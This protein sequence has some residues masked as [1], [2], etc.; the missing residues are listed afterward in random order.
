MNAFDILKERGFVEQI[1]DE[2]GV[3]KH[4]ASPQ[5]VYA[6]FDPSAKSLHLGN[7]V[8]LYGLL[9]LQRL[10]HKSI[11]VL[12][13]ATGMIG[14]PSGKASERKLLDEDTLEQNMAHQKKQFEH[15][16]AIFSDM[17]QQEP[18]IT[19]NLDWTKSLSFI[20]LLRDIGKQFSV[21][22][23]MAKESVKNRLENRE[24]GISFTE[25]SYM[26]LQAYDFLQL[27]KDEECLL[28]VGLNDQ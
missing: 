11:V 28:Q 17:Q 12:G 20:E 7:L 1:T 2:E 13:G 10:G 19:N 8:P 26:I 5:V 16:L 21:N 27:W 14:D 23:M 24:Q 4:L 15:F 6:G 25:F 18:L 9:H 22:A 3:R